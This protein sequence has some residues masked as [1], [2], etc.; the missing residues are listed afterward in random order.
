MII[1]RFDSPEYMGNRGASAADL[2]RAAAQLKDSMKNLLSTLQTGGDIVGVS[3][4]VADWT[5][6]FLDDSKGAMSKVTDP[7]Q[8]SAMATGASAAARKVMDMLSHT[9]QLVPQGVPDEGQL[10]FL[11]SEVRVLLFDSV[12]LT[13]VDN[14]FHSKLGFGDGVHHCQ[15]GV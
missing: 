3:R 13:R 6:K 14:S 9:S 7:N 12:F 8:K 10:Q 1:S 15:R 4:S 2:Q 11:Y 5:N